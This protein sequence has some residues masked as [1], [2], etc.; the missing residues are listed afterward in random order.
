[1]CLLAILMSS[2]EKCLCRSS[3]HFWIG[4]FDSL[5][6]SCMSCLYILE[7]NPLSDISFADTSSHSVECLFVLLMVSFACAEGFQFVVWFDYLCFY[8]PCLRRHI[9]KILLRLMLK[10]ILPMFSSSFMVSK[11][12]F[13]Y[14][15][16]KWSSFILLHAAVQFSQHCLLKRL[17]FLHCIFLPPL[18]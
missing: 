6:L 1:M 3:A 15:I 12:S 18:L 7:I 17:S 13:V 4:L 9:Q 5:I 16:R 2:L 8:C 11:M 14:G 10:S